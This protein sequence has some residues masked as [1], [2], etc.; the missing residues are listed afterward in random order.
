VITAE[1]GPDWLGSRLRS[2]ENPQE[3]PGCSQAQQFSV[4][5]GPV[6][7]PDPGAGPAQGGQDMSIQIDVKCGQEGVKAGF[8]TQGLTPSVFD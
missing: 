1:I 6:S 7:A 2:E 5:Q 3:V 8:H 4:A